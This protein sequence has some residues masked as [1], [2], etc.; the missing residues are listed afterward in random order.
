MAKRK[1]GEHNFVD[2]GLRVGGRAWQHGM[3]FV[4][5]ICTLERRKVE[6]GQDK[7]FLRGKR[8]KGTEACL[9]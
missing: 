4:C 1:P 7:F 9:R 3:R 5:T 6:E 2:D 8:V